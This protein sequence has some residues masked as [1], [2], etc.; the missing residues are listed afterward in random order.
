MLLIMKRRKRC[1]PMLTQSLFFRSHPLS[2][3]TSPEIPK[4]FFPVYTR[5]RAPIIN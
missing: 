3:Y 2:S 5:P 4:T 1:Y